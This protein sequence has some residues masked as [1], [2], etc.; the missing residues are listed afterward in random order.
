MD[1]LPKSKTERAGKLSPAPLTADEPFN[2]LKTNGL[3]A[4]S[5]GRAGRRG[6]LAKWQAA[7]G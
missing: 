7:P 5:S 2:L 3:G 6:A 1:T 4:S